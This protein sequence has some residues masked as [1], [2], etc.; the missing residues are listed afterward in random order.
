MMKIKALL[1]V[2]SCLVL[3]ASAAAEGHGIALKTLVA[4]HLASIG[5]P[6]ARNAAVTR[7]AQG[8]VRVTDIIAG[9]I[10]LGGAAQFISQGDKLKCAF[11]LGVPQYPGEQFVFDGKNPQVATTGPNIRS[12]LGQF[13]FTQSEILR[14]GLLGGSMSTAWP[15]LNSNSKQA[16]LKLEGLKK[17]DGREL[18]DV[19]YTPRNHDA[20]GDLSI[21]LYFDPQTFHHVM[22]IYRLI[23]HDASG[24][25]QK[26]TDET[27]QTVEERFDDFRP[28]DRVTLPMHW[29]IRYHVYPGKASEL[30]WDVHF[31][32]I[33][34]K[35]L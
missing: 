16:R 24:Q 2:A 33:E 34:Q 29:T 13:L 7:F 9:Q 21:H 31:T 22:T 5:T 23:L 32:G 6:A 20:S 30:Q 4:N 18:Y 3:V 25:I 19:D 35:P 26:G 14:S 15:L 12:A 11:Q 8:T 1:L 10:D 28:V 17:I 27:T